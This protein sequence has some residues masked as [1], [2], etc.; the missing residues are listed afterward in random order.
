MINQYLNFVIKLL[1][2]CLSFYLITYFHNWW[3]DI[4]DTRNRFVTDGLILGVITLTYNIILVL[5]DKIKVNIMNDDEKEVI[6]ITEE[7][8]KM[9]DKSIEV[10]KTVEGRIKTIK[11]AFKKVCESSSHTKMSIYNVLSLVAHPCVGKIE[12]S[13][14]E[15][16]KKIDELK[17][18]LIENDPEWWK[19]ASKEDSDEL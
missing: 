6:E 16:L 8:Q 18:E 10:C 11:Y 13:D 7:D 14:D 4:P 2:Y 17:N 5:T 3:F 15:V 19:M 1:I 9:F 12:I